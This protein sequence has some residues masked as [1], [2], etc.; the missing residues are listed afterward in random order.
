MITYVL[1][2]ESD[3]GKYELS[4]GL[5]AI[6]CSETGAADCSVVMFLFSCVFK[7]SSFESSGAY[8][9]GETTIDYLWC[10]TGPF[11]RVSHPK[12]ALVGCCSV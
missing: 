1:F 3:R 7:N 11:V 10:T 6:F 12:S 8:D 4:T 9:Y 2:L 5:V